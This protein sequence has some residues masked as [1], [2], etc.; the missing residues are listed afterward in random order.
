MVDNIQ[1]FKLGPEGRL[2][3]GG[4]SPTVGSTATGLLATDPTKLTIDKEDLT[5]TNLPMDKGEAELQPKMLTSTDA[6]TDTGT[7]FFQTDQFGTIGATLEDLKKRALGI[8]SELGTLAT[9][10]TTTGDGAGTTTEDDDP[11]KKLQME[12][13]NRILE[14]LPTDAGTQ[15]IM[16]RFQ[17]RE[18]A[19]EQADKAARQLIEGR[20]GEAIEEETTEGQRRLT[21]EK[22]ARRGFATNTAMF[23]QMEDTNRKRVRDLERK[24]DDALAVQDIVQAETL[25]DLILKEETALTDARTQFINNLF[26]TSEELRALRGFETPAEAREAETQKTLQTT[27]DSLKLNFADVPGIEN[28]ATISG[29]ISILG[30]RLSEDRRRE[31]YTADLRDKALETSILLD[32]KKADAPDMAWVDIISSETDYRKEYQGRDVIKQYNE[33]SVQYQKMRDAYQRVT[34]N[35][36]VPKGPVDQS[37]IMIFNKILDPRSVV[38]ESEFAITADGDAFIRKG[39]RFWDMLKAGARVTPELRAE[40]VD[41]AEVL[42][43]VH[44]EMKNEIDRE[45]QALTNSANERGVPLSIENIIG[46]IGGDSPTSSFI[47]D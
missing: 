14:A 4:T 35:P 20:A 24:R 22:E 23:R 7:Q 13:T 47:A 10:K 40:I 29:A 44:Q 45:F 16:E 43:N 6:I 38:R 33:S 27:I 15:T 18:T 26:R 28:I 17:K 5:A 9:E 25:N 1:K 34:D 41:T 3:L 8:Q 11:F 42:F 31:L 12:L 39:E 37:L 36:D 2:L 19:T 30:P 21:A 46:S 32:Q